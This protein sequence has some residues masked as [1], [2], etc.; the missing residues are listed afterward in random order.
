MWVRWAGEAVL[1]A[2]PVALT[3]TATAIRR[4]HDRN[5]SDWWMLVFYLAP[6]TLIGIGYLSTNAQALCILASLPPSRLGRRRT[7]LPPRHV[8]AESLRAPTSRSGDAGDTLRRTRP[9]DL[10][11][12]RLPRPALTPRS[13]FAFT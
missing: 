10:P 5:K 9:S 4:L 6:A 7:R 8:R 12:H 13:A 1:V 2:V 11:W 3:A